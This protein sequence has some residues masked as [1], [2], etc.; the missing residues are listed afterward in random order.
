[1]RFFFNGAQ[2]EHWAACQ[3]DELMGVVTWEPTHFA[4]DVLWVAT[5]PAWEKQA[6][7]YLLPYVQRSIHNGHTLVVNYP[8]GR[9]NDAFIQA[10]FE[11]Q[12]V[13]IWMEVKFK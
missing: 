5:S 1:M 10:G 8:A 12:N 11:R 2:I 3:F 6:I 9:A 7:S 13:L 4:Q